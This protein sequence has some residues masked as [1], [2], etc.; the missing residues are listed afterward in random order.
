MEMIFQYAWRN[1]GKVPKKRGSL[2]FANAA[3][4]GSAMPD[5]VMNMVSDEFKVNGGL[6]RYEADVNMY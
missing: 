6:G 3:M 4:N 2:V 5:A 1:F